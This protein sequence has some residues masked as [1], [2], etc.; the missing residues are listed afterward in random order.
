MIEILRYRV[1]ILKRVIK[2]ICGRN[3]A[4]GS[5]FTGDRIS[6]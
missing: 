3:R 1:G 2:A 5:G 6:H 4:G